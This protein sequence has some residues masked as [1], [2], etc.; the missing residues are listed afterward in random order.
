MSKHPDRIKKYGAPQVNGAISG[1][2]LNLEVPGIVTAKM[3]NKASVNTAK[4]GGGDSETWAEPPIIIPDRS[5]NTAVFRSKRGG[6]AIIMNDEPMTESG[7]IQIVHKSGTVIQMDEGGSVFISSRGNFVN[8]TDTSSMER[9]GVDK[10]TNVGGN[11]NI[12]VDGGDGNVVIQGD[13][14]VEC[15]NFNVTARGKTTINSAEAL[16]LRGAKVSIEAHVD[17]IDMMGKNIKI[18]ATESL[19]TLS[20]K[21]TYISSETQLNLKSGD[22][23]FL[24]GGSDTHIKSG[25]SLLASASSDV[26]LSG[27]VIYL[28][29][30]VRMAEGGALGSGNTAKAASPGIKPV[31]SVMPNPPARRPKN[32]STSMIN[33]LYSSKYSPSGGATDISPIGDTTKTI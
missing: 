23:V 28:D 22:E 4:P 17:N 3:A 20:G 25:G 5:V 8:S 14:N 13:F 9:V 2:Q 26:K 10:S 31:A 21:S 32:P 7:Y 33:D 15:E 19:S 18:G 6:N 24:T 1:Q 29:D 12:T 16:E 27:G 11:W 30:I